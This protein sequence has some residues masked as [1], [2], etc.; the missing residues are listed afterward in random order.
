MDEDPSERGW[1]FASEDD[2]ISVQEQ[3]SPDIALSELPTGNPRHADA[4]RCFSPEVAPFPDD[5]VRGRAESPLPIGSGRPEGPLPSSSAGADIV[6]RITPGMSALDA[7]ATVRQLVLQQRADVIWIRDRL[8]N[9]HRNVIR[10]RYL[11][12]KTSNAVSRALYIQGK[13]E[14]VMR[15]NF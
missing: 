7:I 3:S 12:E 5:V 14:E 10:S 4:D 8:R 1:K 13:G 15:I 2:I 6:A 11:A 9:H